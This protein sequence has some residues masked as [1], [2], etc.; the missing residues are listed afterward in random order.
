MF[1]RYRSKFV[2]VV[3]CCNNNL[4]IN[5]LLYMYTYR[6]YNGIFYLIQA[7]MYN[8]NPKCAS[9]F[10]I[11]MKIAFPKT[12]KC[13]TF[14][15]FYITIHIYFYQYI[16]TTYRQ[17]VIL[18]KLSERVSCFIHTTDTSP[19]ANILLLEILVEYWTIFPYFNIISLLSLIHTVSYI[20]YI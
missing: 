20:F 14:A 17:Y 11:C 12:Y 15:F 1:H 18:E 7:R 5:K 10:G 8:V 13:H 4:Y 3:A 16:Y 6:L 2:E 9:L 19:F